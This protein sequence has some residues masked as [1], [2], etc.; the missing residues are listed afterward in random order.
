MTRRQ[1]LLKLGYRGYLCGVL[2]SKLCP[3]PPSLQPPERARATASVWTAMRRTRR[4]RSHGPARGRTGGTRRRRRR[5]PPG[6]GGRPRTTGGGRGGRTASPGC[7]WP[8]TIRPTPRT[9]KREQTSPVS[10]MLWGSPPDDNDGCLN[11]SL[12]Y[13]LSPSTLAFVHDKCQ[14]N[15]NTRCQPGLNNGYWHVCLVSIH[16]DSM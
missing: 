2:L 14:P 6:R 12:V 10:L 13:I 8:V 1:L 9:P 7:S 11:F 16:R 3:D 4:S 5:G 15:F